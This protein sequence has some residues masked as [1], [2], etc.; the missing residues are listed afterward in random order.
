[1]SKKKNRNVSKTCNLLRKEKCKVGAKESPS[2]EKLRVFKGKPN[3][4]LWDNRKDA[5]KESQELLRFHFKSG[6]FLFPF[7]K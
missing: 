7:L 4:L 5:L 2:A 1:M 6:K 3:T